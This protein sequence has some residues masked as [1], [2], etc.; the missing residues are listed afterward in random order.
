MRCYNDFAAYSVF[1]ITLLWVIEKKKIIM[2]IKHVKF[3]V[4][5]ADK[6]FFSEHIASSAMKLGSYDETN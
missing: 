3:I 2:V 6:D 5:A 4:V 1:H